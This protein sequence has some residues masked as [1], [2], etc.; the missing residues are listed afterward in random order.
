[1][2]SLGGHLYGR[3]EISI[4]EREWWVTETELNR[5]KLLDHYSTQWI[6]DIGPRMGFLAVGV[7]FGICILAVLEMGEW[8]IT[9]LWAGIGIGFT[10]CIVA[11]Y[12]RRNWRSAWKF[13]I[14]FYQMKFR[15]K[16]QEEPI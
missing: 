6:N 13:S 11:N 4:E 9:S 3:R 8:T 7:V 5:I 12:F 14:H 15:R 16:R 2:P 10:T 1:M